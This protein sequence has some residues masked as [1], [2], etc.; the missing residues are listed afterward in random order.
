[1][2]PALVPVAG[3]L[4]GGLLGKLFGGNKNKLAE[5]SYKKAAEYLES[6][7]IPS[8]EAQQIILQ[9]PEFISQFTPDAETVEGLGDS[10]MGGVQTDPRLRAAQMDALSSLV[11]QGKNPL[12]DTEKASLNQ[13]RRDVASDAQARNNAILQNMSA[14]GAGGSGVELAAQLAS[15]QA[16]AQRAGEESDRE[17]AMAQQRALESIAQAGSLGGSIRGQEFSEDSAKASAADAIAKFNAANRQEVQQRNIAAKNAAKL[18]EANVRQDLEGTRTANFNAQEEYNK[19]LLQQDYQNKMGKA[20]QLS[21][22][23][24]AQAGRQQ[25]AAANTAQNW[26]NIGSSVGAGLASINQPKYNTD[27]GAKIKKYDPNT[28]QLLE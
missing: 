2:L 21:G 25:Q 11:E 23:A 4:V 13:S 3:N 12:T 7:G 27:T 1:M 6:V 20:E 22:L 14:R 16:S 10:A 24:N 5:Q 9:N 19:K 18:R 8:V 17:K 26:A 15:S 28:G